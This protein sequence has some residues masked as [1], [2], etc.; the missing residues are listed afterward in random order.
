MVNEVNVIAI[1][2]PSGSGKSTI[3]KIIAEKLNLVYLDTGAMF[4]AIAYVLDEK[5]IAVTDDNKIKYFLETINFNYQ[6]DEN[7]LVEINGVNLTE[8]IRQHF[9]SGLAS[10]YSQ[11][12]SVREFLKHIQRE[13]AS[14]RPSILDGRDIGTIIFPDAILK[15]YLVADAEIRAKRRLSQ[16]TEQNSN[17]TYDLK[18]ILEDIIARDYADQNRAIAPL[19]KAE[20]AIEFDSTKLS[21][22]ELTHEIIKIYKNRTH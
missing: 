17:E 13:I 20:D 1:D 16:L 12:K 21:V 14:T 8:S 9:V 6:K 3:A 5:K 4:R 2:G 19:K 11:V 10:K 7:C 22:D 18:K 15:I